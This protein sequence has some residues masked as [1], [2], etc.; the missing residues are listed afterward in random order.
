MCILEILLVKSSE[1]SPVLA[2][3][4][5]ESGQCEGPLPCIF[6]KVVLSIDLS[7][8]NFS[9]SISHFL[10]KKPW[11]LMDLEILR[12]GNNQL[13][14]KLPDC[15]SNWKNLSIV[16]LS[17][18]NFSG[19]IPSSMGSLIFLQSLHLRSNNLSG[20]FPLSLQNCTEL[21]TLDIGGN[22]LRGSI[23][24]WIGS[25]LLK[26]RILSLRFNEFYG[27]LP[28]QLCALSSLQILDVSYNYLSGQIPRCFNNFSAMA[29]S[30]DY[31]ADY[32]FSQSFP[33]DLSSNL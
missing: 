20:E 29:Q 3:R 33:K 25:K 1:Y 4:Q 22:N 11:E 23:P 9:G 14:G 24:A 12:L 28:N 15:W 26:M 2:S 8:N 27:H 19:N 18:N 30:S 32:F 10:C 16:Y 31:Y 6:S 5:C 7:S 13:S 17:S 21:F